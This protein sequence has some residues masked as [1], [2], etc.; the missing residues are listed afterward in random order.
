MGKYCE[1]FWPKAGIIARRTVGHVRLALAILVRM[2]LVGRESDSRHHDR[3]SAQR[4]YAFRR[5]MRPTV[6]VA[7]SI[8]PL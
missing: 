5:R 6:R 7:V 8:P 3:R 1:T 2:V 4:P